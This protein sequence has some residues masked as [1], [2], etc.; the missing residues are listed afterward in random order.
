MYVMEVRNTRMQGIVTIMRV[1]MNDRLLQM[2]QL[3]L[4]GLVMTATVTK[5]I[6][7]ET[8]HWS[9]KHD[10]I[11]PMSGQAWHTGRELGGGVEREK[12]CLG[13]GEVM[14]PA[15]LHWYP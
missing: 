5:P 11:R 3:K 4:E 8:A 12:G 14:P 13:Y 10:L 7:I 6:D 1:I 15:G 9:P 2:L